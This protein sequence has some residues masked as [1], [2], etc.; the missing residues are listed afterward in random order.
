M[1]DTARI[2]ESDET[3]PRLSLING[4]GVARA[5]AWPGVGSKLRSMARIQL[6]AVSRTNAM[7]HPM[8][9]VYYIISGDGQVVDSD[10]ASSQPLIRGSMAHIEPGT[11]YTFVAGAAGMELI[12]GPCPPDPA[13]Y[14]ELGS[15]G[16]GG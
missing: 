11:T 13:L 6:A 14:R 10:A 1:S 15:P 4:E 3:C 5:V 16:L 2:L 9:A 7:N 12:G 8:E